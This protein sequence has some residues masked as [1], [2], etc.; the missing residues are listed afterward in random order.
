M[1]SSSVHPRDIGRIAEI[2]ISF[3]YQ[4]KSYIRT[5][6]FLALAIIVALISTAVILVEIHAGMFTG[7]YNVDEFLL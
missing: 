2:K 7:K 1:A 6:R 4:L 5:K 3:K